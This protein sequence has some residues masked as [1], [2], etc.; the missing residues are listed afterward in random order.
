MCKN[1]CV[2]FGVQILSNI[3]K[4]S[5]QLALFSRE[6]FLNTLLNQYKL[7]SYYLSLVDDAQYI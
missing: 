5:R 1:T 4:L 6:I 2:T 7:H 3:R